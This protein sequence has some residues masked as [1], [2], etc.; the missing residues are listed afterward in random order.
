MEIRSLLYPILFPVWEFL[1]VLLLPSGYY[2][3]ASCW[4]FNPPACSFFFRPLLVFF[5][6]V[7]LPFTLV[8]LPSL[9]KGWK[10][11]ALLSSSAG[12]TVIIGTA[13]LTF[14]EGI[15]LLAVLILAPLLQPAFSRIAGLQIERREETLWAVS[16]VLSFLAV[17]IVVR[18][19]LAVAR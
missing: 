17:W 12:V 7:A 19:S 6:V 13:L 18:M 15:A 10:E 9:W 14:S 11:I 4:S 1:L 16:A 5:L 8:T 2:V 3:S